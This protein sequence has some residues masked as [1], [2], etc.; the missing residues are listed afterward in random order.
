MNER[1]DKGLQWKKIDLH[2]HT[3]ASKEDTID[4][5]I[6]PSDIVDKA[7][8]TGLDA[9]CIS[10]HNSGDWVD[11][12]KE[13]AQ[14]KALTVFPGVEITAPSVKINIHMNATAGF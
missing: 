6:K 7:V 3:P 4:K 5:S 14:G 8:S 9:I 2:M 1:Y 13:A 11:K 10:D 12:V